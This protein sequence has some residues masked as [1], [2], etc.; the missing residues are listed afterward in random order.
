MDAAVINDGVAALSGIGAETALFKDDPHSPETRPYLNVI[1]ARAADDRDRSLK[2]AAVRFGRPPASFSASR[3]WAPQSWVP[4]SV[5]PKSSSNAR[6]CRSAA[7]AWYAAVST[8][9]YPWWAPSYSS[10]RYRTPAASSVCS[11]VL[12][13]SAVIDASSSA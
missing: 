4:P 10:L 5:R 9:V 7:S 3:F 11:S 6:Q 12:I 8:C 13:C 2:Q 1:A